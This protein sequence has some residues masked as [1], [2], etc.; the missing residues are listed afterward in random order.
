MGSTKTE[1]RMQ[2]DR[3]EAAKRVAGERVAAMVEDGMCLGLGTGSTAARAIE[4]LGRRIR[5]EGL[6]LAGVAT[7]F[8]AERMARAHGIR[9]LTFD[10]VDELDLAFDG[11]DEVDPAL[12]LIKG[13][14]AA[15]TREKVVASCARRFV[16]LVDES[17][18]VDRLGTKRPVPVEVLPMAAAPVQRAL[19]RMGARAELRMGQQK[20][21]PVVTDQGLWVIDATFPGGLDDPAA[22]GRALRALP[23]VLDHGLFIG[24]ATEVLVGMPG[25]DVR[26]LLPAEGHR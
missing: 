20:D 1:D 23:G 5:E 24:M 21:G 12:N 17:K 9:L 7:S 26:R 4:A 25:G 16:V 8:F 13:R 2:E 10:E 18:L 6:R 15:H 19:E 14:G 22:C 11:A 3:Q